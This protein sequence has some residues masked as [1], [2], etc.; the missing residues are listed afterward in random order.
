MGWA[1]RRR[2]R[3]ADISADELGHHR[4]E[5]GDPPRTKSI[6]QFKL[7]QGLPVRAMVTLRGERM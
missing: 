1:G 5:G 4:P 7:R 2:T 6:A 3:I